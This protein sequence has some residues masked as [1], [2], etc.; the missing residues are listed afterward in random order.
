[1]QNCL[2]TGNELLNSGDI[3]E[4]YETYSQINLNSFQNL[5]KNLIF[6]LLNNL[7]V[8]LLNLNRPLEALEAFNSPSLIHSLEDDDE[9][10]E[11]DENKEEKKETANSLLLKKRRSDIALNKAII[12]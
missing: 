3:Q 2:E 10:L 11:I 6:Q 1:M 9:I 12:L 4:A 8:T 5:N 7:A